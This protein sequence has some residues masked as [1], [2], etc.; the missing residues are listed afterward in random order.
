M[1]EGDVSLDGTKDSEL[2]SHSITDKSYTYDRDR[3]RA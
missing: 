2:L 1:L 3:N